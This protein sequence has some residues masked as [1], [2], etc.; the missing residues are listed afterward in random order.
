MLAM[1]PVAWAAL[2]AWAVRAPQAEWRQEANLAL[3][4]MA[5]A[6]APMVVAQAAPVVG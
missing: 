4:P 6:L 5:V 3:T 1:E 2:V